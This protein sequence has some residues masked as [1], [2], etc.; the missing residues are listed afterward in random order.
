MTPYSL[1]SEYYGR[2]DADDIDWVMQ[3]FAEESCY[4]RADAEYKGKAEIENFFRNTRK[5]R[6]V[7][8]VA[9]IHRLKNKSIT[10]REF[11]GTGVA[12]DERRVKFVDFWFFQ[13]SGKVELRETYL[14]V[15]NEIVRD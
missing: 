8:E 15:G 10:R 6:G 13:N 5:I 4:M 1:I 9:D 14:A 12:G 7:H 11:I 3:L 2:I